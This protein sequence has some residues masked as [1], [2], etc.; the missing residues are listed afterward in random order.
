MDTVI[1]ENDLPIRL[2][3]YSTAF[4]REA[5]TYG[6]DTSGILRQHQFDKL[7]MFSFV[8]PRRSPVEHEFFLAVQEAMMQELNL[9]YRVVLIS[10]GDMVWTDAKQYDLE[11]W[12]PASNGGEYRETHSASNSTD[13]QSRRLDTK[14]R[15]REGKTEF[16]HTVNG[17]AFA[18]GRTLI[19]ILENYQAEDGSVRVPEALRPH[20]HGITEIRR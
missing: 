11:T 15:S 16:V 8:H 4:R 1:E 7:E 18:I 5:G 3:G 6:K 9:P 17:T 2:A 13:F 19:A 10:T 20:M 14:F 12:L